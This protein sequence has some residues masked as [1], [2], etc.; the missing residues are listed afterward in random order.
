MNNQPSPELRSLIKVPAALI[1]IIMSALAA[2]ILA[3]HVLKYGITKEADEGPTAH[4]WQLLM[5]GQIPVIAFF[6][7]KWLRRS[8][9][10]AVQ[11]LAVQL[12]A[13]VISFAPVLFLG[14]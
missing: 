8:P 7:L 13:A 14:L 12:L 9:F 6:A 1:P 11:V 4:L 5:A 3:V 10:P 2:A